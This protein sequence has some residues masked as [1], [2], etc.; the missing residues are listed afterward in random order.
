LIG[1][2]EQPYGLVEKAEEDDARLAGRFAAAA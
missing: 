1:E 2:G